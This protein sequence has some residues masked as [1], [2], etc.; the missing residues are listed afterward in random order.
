LKA[1]VVLKSGGT[2]IPGFSPLRWLIVAEGPGSYA[3]SGYHVLKGPSPGVEYPKLA[4]LGEEEFRELSAAPEVRRMIYHSY[5]VTA[6]RDG[7]VVT[8]SD[9]L[10]E[11]S[12]LWYPPYFKSVRVPGLKR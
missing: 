7:E 6:A 12:Y 10:R 2:A 3:V 4:G 9:P 1:F 5:A 11:G 8:F